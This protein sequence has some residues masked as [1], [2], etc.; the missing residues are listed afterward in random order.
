MIVLGD[1]NDDI[2][3]S[4]YNKKETPFIALKNDPTVDF[5]TKYLSYG[6]NSSS[7]YG[8][9]IDHILI[10]NEL[11]DDYDRSG[12]FYTL[13]LDLDYIDTTSDHYP[14]FSVFK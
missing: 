9:V 5:V 13:D 10:T 7:I 14:V 3:V 8:S 6:R 12:I 4:N 1:W 2:D 11:F